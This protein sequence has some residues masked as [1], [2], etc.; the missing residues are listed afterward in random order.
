MANEVHERSPASL[1]GECWNAL[2][3]WHRENGRH[4]L[5]WRKSPTPWRTLLAETLL[6]RTNAAQVSPLFE[7]AAEKFPEPGAVIGMPSEWL[8]ATHQAGLRWRAQS[9][10]RACQQIVDRHNGLVPGNRHD[11]LELAGVGHYTADAV[12]CF[13]FGKPTYIVDT[14]TIR[15]AARVFGVVLDPAYHRTR[16]TRTQVSRLG[17]EGRAPS[18]Q[19]NLALLDL[20]AMV[21]R[22]SNPACQQCPIRA[23]CVYF[24]TR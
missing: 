12:L 11:L 19:E 5:P 16:Y 9:F 21:C 6:H 22:P 10:I 8:R 15:L 7:A 17:R 14:N 1:P 24:L 20:A 2:V 13:G 3:D 23:C 18:P 4:E